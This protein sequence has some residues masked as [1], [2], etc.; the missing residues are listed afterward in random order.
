MRAVIGALVMMSIQEIHSWLMKF[1]THRV[2]LSP[3]VMQ[4]F[5]GELLRHPPSAAL[6][7]CMSSLRT[8]ESSASTA[9]QCSP[10]MLPILT[11][12]SVSPGEGDD[13][14]AAITKSAE[15]VLAAEVYT[16]DER[17]RERH[18]R[19]QHSLMLFV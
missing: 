1:G 11:T 6:H 12:A 10:K 4:E 2:G 9:P 15:A 8:K 3:S 7:R 13:T 17:R 18:D 19:R 14:L 5:S 16:A